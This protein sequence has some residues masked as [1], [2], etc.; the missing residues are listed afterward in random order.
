MKQKPVQLLLWFLIALPFYSAWGSQHYLYFLYSENASAYMQLLRVPEGGRPV[1]LTSIQARF[2]EDTDFKALSGNIAQKKTNPG[3]EFPETVRKM[4]QKMMEAQSELPDADSLKAP[5]ST[6]SVLVSVAGYET[7]HND[8]LSQTFPPQLTRNRKALAKQHLIFVF[9][10]HC[11]Q[12]DETSIRFSGDQDYIRQMALDVDARPHLAL[13]KATYDLLFLADPTLKT[14]EW[15]TWHS[16]MPHA[17][18]GSKNDLLPTGGSYSLGFLTKLR[19]FSNTILAD[20]PIP[21]IGLLCEQVREERRRAIEFLKDL[22]AANQQSQEELVNR[23]RQGKR[24]NELGIRYLA[25][26]IA[27]DH[28]PG[29][30]YDAEDFLIHYGAEH[31]VN[32][33]VFLLPE[34]KKLNLGSG[35][36][37]LAV[38]PVYIF[39]AFQAMYDQHP[40]LKRYMDEKGQEHGFKLKRLTTDEARNLENQAAI[41]LYNSLATDNSNTSEHP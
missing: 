6:V 31:L 41:N 33:V 36:Q 27:N 17:R 7:I 15:Y 29:Y 34:V 37:P 21:C 20:P 11:I 23:Y 4:A 16:K 24:N 5:D 18:F 12:L 40:F 22:S 1:L 10:G 13:F 19:F 35:L 30:T 3:Q 26:L 28:K 38:E 14:S 8:P 39:G 2:T 9:S 25:L 32:E